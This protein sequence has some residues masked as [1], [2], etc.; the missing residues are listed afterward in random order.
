M[1]EG[2]IQV[3]I[4]SQQSLFRQGIQL[5]LSEAADIQVLSA[6]AI[7]EGILSQID[8]LPPD[9]ILIDIDG[10]PDQGLT[11][12]RKIKQHSPSIAI[13]MLSSNPS[14][15]QLFQVLKA[16]AAAYLSKEVTA[17]Q[18]ID[19]IKRVAHGEHPINESL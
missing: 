16:Q 6:A 10:S 2:K 4:I 5:S 7:D 19:A 15:E 8:T 11:L 9:V 1:E 12:A 18:L 3:F 14:D 13:V 17:E